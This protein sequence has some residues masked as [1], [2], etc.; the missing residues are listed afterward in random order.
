MQSLKKLLADKKEMMELV[1]YVVAG[2]ITTALSVLIS[3]GMYMLLSEDH[4]INGASPEQVMIGNTVSWIVCVVFAFWINRRMVFCVQDSTRRDTLKEF[5]AFAGARV[6]S[7]ALFEE[8]LAALLTTTGMLNT[9]N[10]LIVLVFVM[11]FNYVASKFWIFKPKTD[12]KDAQT[13][14]EG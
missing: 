10:R 13:P 6:V 3:Y 11:V 1:R 5:T 8:G 4:T 14:P 2:F 9:I 12:G 7:W